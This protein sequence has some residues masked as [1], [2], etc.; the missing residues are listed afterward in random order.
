VTELGYLGVDMV[1]DRE[2]GPLILEMNARPGLNIQIANGVGLAA[3]IKRIDEIRDAIA[4]P[5][6]RAAA[7][8]REFSTKWGDS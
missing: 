2:Y 3:R 1:I 8:R 7:S 5:E 4:T 6:A